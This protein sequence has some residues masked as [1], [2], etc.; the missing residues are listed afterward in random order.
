[1]S[2]SKCATFFGALAALVVP[3]SADRLS[4]TIRIL[5]QAHV[6]S[7][8][9]KKMQRYVET[10]LAAIDINVKWIDCAA[11]LDACKAVRGRNEFWLRILAQN[12]PDLNPDT[13]LMGLTQRGEKPGEIPCI[14]IFYP[15]VERLAEKTHTEQL[16]GAAVAHEIGHM[17][18][19]NNREAHSLNGIMKGVWLQREFELINLGSL[20]FTREQG[21]RIRAA[22]TAGIE[23]NV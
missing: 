4:M 13:E 1:M 21:E 6:S 16:L 18:L 9:I 20:N 10:T 11:N 8:K 17:Y 7:G 12:P 2:F 3:A 5:D 15:I 14:N 22:I 23:G 19:G